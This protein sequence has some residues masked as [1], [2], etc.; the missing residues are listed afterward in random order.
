MDGWP[1]EAAVAEELDRMVPLWMTEKGIPIMEGSDA[2][3]IVIRTTVGFS[4]NQILSWLI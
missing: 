2:R 1:I 3:L 4:S